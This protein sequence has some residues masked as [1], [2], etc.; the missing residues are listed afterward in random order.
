MISPLALIP[1]AEEEQE[2]A[3]DVTGMLETA[4]ALCYRL[5]GETHLAVR[6][7]LILAL[8]V[9]PTQNA[10]RA[11]LRRAGDEDVHLRAQVLTILRLMPEALEAPSWKTSWPT[12]TGW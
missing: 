9:N 6:R 12:K 10:V 2:P 1:E 7:A 5:Q 4:R 3:P 11:M 8:I